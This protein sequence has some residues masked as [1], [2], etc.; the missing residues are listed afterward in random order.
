MKRHAAPAFYHREM[1]WFSL[2]DKDV[3][4]KNETK[5]V[6][7]FAGVVT[8]LVSNVGCAALPWRSN[9]PAETITAE[10]YAQQ[11]VENISYDNSIDFAQDY[12]P[13]PAAASSHTSPPKS[14]SAASSSSRASCCSH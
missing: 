4:M 1:D 3:E 8:L 10:Q 7:I 2:C 11:A 13:S 14:F 12:Q 6:A 5:R 9:K